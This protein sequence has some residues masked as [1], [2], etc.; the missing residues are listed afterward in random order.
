MRFLTVLCLGG[1]GRGGG[2]AFFQKEG[3]YSLGKLCRNEM[4]ALESVLDQV[5]MS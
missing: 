4:W 1:E 2:S 3:V 5:E